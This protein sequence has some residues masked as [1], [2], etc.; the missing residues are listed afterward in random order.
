MNSEYDYDLA[1]I[2][3]GPGG[4]V[5][6]VKAAQNGLKIAVIECGKTGGTCLNRGCIPTKTLL[7]AAELYREFKGAESFGIHAQGVTFDIG[8]MSARKEEVVAQL[9]GG[10]EQL[11]KANK[12]TNI[13]GKATV[14]GAHQVTVESA[15]GI[16]QITAENILIATGS[17]PS[18]PPIEGIGLPGVVTSDEL[19]SGDM[20][21]YRSLVIIGGGVIGV[22]FASIYSALGCE[23]TVIEAMDRIL[24]QMDKEISQNLAMILK[25][26]GVKIYASAKVAKISEENG[27]ACTFEQKGTLQTVTAEGILAA[28]GRKP[29]TQG[30]FGEPFSVECERGA[31]TVNDRFQT[32]V[33][34]V[35][36]IGDVIRGIQLAHA[37]SAQ[38]SNA[39]CAMLGKP[40][41]VNLNVVPSCVYT[42]PEIACVGMTADEAKAKDIAVKT[43]KFL[44][45]ANAKTVITRQERGFIKL[46]FEE[47]TGVLLGAQLMCARA[48]D[49]IGE[50][51]A[52]VANG[53]TQEQMASVIRPHPTFCEGIT[54]AAEDA[55]GT[56]VHILPKLR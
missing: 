21:L 24:P 15:E 44:M 6:A 53:L 37:A 41:A 18:L 23:V 17:V 9:R 3:A 39:V 47:K 7:H 30:L 38:G 48:T 26:R 29:N 4:Y 35:Y 42:E 31:V 14:T 16:R 46:V 32:S 36:A 51:A 50:L 55:E 11:F 5:A 43:G 2:G 1:V 10:V 45:S 12:I 19:L 22:E 13:T 56:A 52:A 20:K 28:V 34:S 49:L 27:L 25:K 33:P 8:E 54:E 40:A